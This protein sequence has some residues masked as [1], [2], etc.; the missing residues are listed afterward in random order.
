MLNDQRVII[1]QSGVSQPKSVSFP[2]EKK[3]WIN[4]INDGLIPFNLQMEYADKWD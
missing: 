2:G 3:Q 4:L 1:N